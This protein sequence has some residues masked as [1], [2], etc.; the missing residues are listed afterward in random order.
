MFRKTMPLVLLLSA[1]MFPAAASAQSTTTGLK[2][3]LVITRAGVT[4]V[5]PPE[6]GGIWTVTDSTYDCEGALQ[7]VEASEDTLCPGEPAFDPQQSPYP[8]DCTGSADA[9]N[10]DVTCTG[11]AELFPDCQANF[12]S[13]LRGTRTGESYFVVSTTEITYSGSGTGCEFVPP[14]C[15]QINSHATR[16]GPAPVAYCQTPAR[17]TS[18]GTLKV[19]YR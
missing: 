13:T 14:F 4:I 9:T 7:N 18:W 6:W 11:S 3:Q 2:H 16:T 8:I 5:V 1:V 12:T 17:P 19:R 15:M 10:I